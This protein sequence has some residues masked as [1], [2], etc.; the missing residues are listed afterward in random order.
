MPLPLG[1]MLVTVSHAMPHGTCSFAKSWGRQFDTCGL[2]HRGVKLAA[3]QLLRNYKSH[4]A[5]AFG[6][7]ACNC[8]SCNASWDL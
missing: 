5:S 2:D 6:S 4:H 8:Q 1:A 7:H 3:L